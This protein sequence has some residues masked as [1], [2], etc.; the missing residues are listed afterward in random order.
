METVVADGSSTIHRFLGYVP[1]SRTESARLRRKPHERQRTVFQ[2]G[3]LVRVEGE[4]TR[5]E[6]PTIDPLKG[7]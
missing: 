5:A 3:L 6:R 4:A 2:V 7:T 1:L